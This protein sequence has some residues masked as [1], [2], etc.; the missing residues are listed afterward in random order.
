MISICI[1][2]YNC[3]VTSLVND[4]HTQG[5]L[6][7]IPFEIIL[8]DDA[9]K[10]EFKKINERILLD[11]VKYIPLKENIGRAK[12]RNL[13]LQYV[14]YD[15]LL[16]LDCDSAIISKA[17]LA[18]YKEAIEKRHPLVISGKSIYTNIKPERKYRLRWKYGIKK[19]SLSK[20]YEKIS[21]KSFM[22]NNFLIL[23][24][25][26]AENLFEESITG[27]G[28]EDTLFGFNLKKRG[29]SV[30]RIYNPV[31][32]AHLDE[33]IDFLEKTEESIRN[34]LY[35][36]DLMNYD[37]ELVEDLK[38]VSTYNKLKSRKIVGFVKLPFF[39]LKPALKFLLEKGYFSLWMFDFYKLGIFIKM[40][41]GLE[42]VS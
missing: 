7:N 25:V 24:S 12:I 34:L 39:I 30:E 17:F 26:L 31:L 22:T 18:Q 1:P 10:E 32:N 9:S 27:Y 41:K 4:L 38:I 42:Q 28:H 14:Q 8:I 36:L 6:L 35:I 15:Y 29:I 21:N 20:N 40:K 3:D 11:H 23:R 5:K 13:F 33:N 16:F 37:P 2:V 19:E